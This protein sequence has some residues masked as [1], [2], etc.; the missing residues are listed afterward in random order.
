M[1]T[2]RTGVARNEAEVPPRLRWRGVDGRSEA[3][4]GER[5]LGNGDDNG[6]DE[7]DDDD[8]DDDDED[9]DEEGR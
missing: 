7:V 9:D 5:V 1:E 8:D 2:L 3:S 4:A 6:D